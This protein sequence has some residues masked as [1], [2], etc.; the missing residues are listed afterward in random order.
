MKKFVSIFVGLLLCI[1]LAQSSPW[2]IVANKD[3]RS[4]NTIDMGTA[5]PTVYGPFDFG[6]YLAT[7]L[8][9]VVSPDSRFALI[10]DFFTSSVYMIDITDPTNPTLMNNI[11]IG[12]Q[13]SEDIAISPDGRFAIV[14]DGMGSGSGS[15]Y[16]MIINLADVSQVSAYLLSTSS[17]GAQAVTITRDNMVVVCDYLH[18][19]LIYGPINSSLT[20]LQWEKT[21]STS[22]GVIN[23]EAS[24]DGNTILACCINSGYVDIFQKTSSNELIPGTTSTIRIP[25][26][27]Q[28]VAFSRQGDRA[29]VLGSG[30]PDSLSWLQ[31]SGP[32]NATVGG[33]NSA[34]FASTNYGYG[35]F[36]I[37]SLA[38][39]PDGNYVFYGQASSSQKRN[40]FESVSLPS[41]VVSRITT[42]VDTPTGVAAFWGAVMPPLDLSLTEIENN[43]IFYKQYITRLSWQ[44]YPSPLRT[45]A[46][47]RI[48]QKNQG[49]PDSAFTLITEVN[50]ETRQYDDRALER[51]L[52]S[53]AISAV[54]DVGQESALAKFND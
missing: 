2:V 26:G 12:A 20:G 41:Y 54:D 29:Y 30:N 37:D 23:V 15:G 50:G 19:R 11:P 52:F 42:G 18:N 9:V 22:A 48:Y 24:P 5:T 28:C 49:E 51:G 40:Y 34:F 1:S 53:F 8:D 6:L 38:V 14:T 35:Y 21:V 3:G 27:P 47:Y 10:T 45:I 13:N 46:A 32:G 4:I 31:I 44:P 33:L 39:S 16:L 25:T 7:V 43:L 17:G 36:G